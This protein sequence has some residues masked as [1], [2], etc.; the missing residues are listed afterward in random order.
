M[1]HDEDVRVWPI[2]ELCR[3]S[4]VVLQVDAFEAVRRGDVRLLKE[5]IETGHPRIMDRDADNATLL[6]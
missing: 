3:I 6:H 5:L 1:M 2:C 4:D